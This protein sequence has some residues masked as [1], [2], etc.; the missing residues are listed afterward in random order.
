MAKLN[1]QMTFFFTL[2]AIPTPLGCASKAEVA[3]LEAELETLRQSVKELQDER[4]Q[5]H[6]TM[7]RLESSFL[8]VSVRRIELGKTGAEV[9][10]ENGEACI[11][12]SSHPTYSMDEKYKDDGVWGYATFDCTSRLRGPDKT[13][14][15]K[16]GFGVQNDY[17][18]DN[19]KFRKATISK[20]PGTPNA[21]YLCLRE[22]YY[23][24]AICAKSV[25][26]TAG[27]ASP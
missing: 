7:S 18:M 3:T 14:C 23:D 8:A 10:G 21:G 26:P 22:S 19:E 5:Q 12:V 11:S 25:L 2:V 15:G 27:S 24:S 1:V 20:I 17:W 13:K 4:K 6:E 9:C 16:D